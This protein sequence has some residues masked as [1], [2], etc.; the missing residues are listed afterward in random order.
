[1]CTVATGAEP[2]SRKPGSTSSDAGPEHNF[3]ESVALFGNRAL[4]GAAGVQDAG[5]FTGAAYV[6][7]RDDAGAWMQVAKLTANDMH[8]Q[9]YFG[10]AVALFGDR[11]L[12]GVFADDDMGFTS[13][14]AYVFERDASGVW[15]QTAKLYADDGDSND[16]FGTAVAL[17]GERA[18]V[19]ASGDEDR[20]MGAGAAYVLER[21]GRG[22]WVQVQKLLASDGAAI[23]VFGAAVS[24]SGKRALVGA[25]RDDDMGEE[26][27]A[28]YVFE[29][30]SSGTWTE[31]AKLTASDGTA[32][33][34]LGAVS[35]SGGRALLGASKAV[36]MGVTTGAAYVFES[37]PDRG[38]L[39]V[40]ALHASDG[41]ANDYFGISVSVLGD[42]ALVGAHYED[43]GLYGDQ[44]AAYVY[45]LGVAETYCQST[46]NSTGAPAVLAVTGSD[47]VSANELALFALPV[48]PGVGYFCFGG[49]RVHRPFG[50]GVLCAGGPHLRLGPLGTESYTLEQQLDLSTPPLAGSVFGGSRWNL[51]AVF[52]DGPA[53]GFNTSSALTVLFRP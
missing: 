24:L 5:L 21:N 20:G 50:N 10:R 15:N 42:R 1:M 46:L 19:G 18:L 32:G 35:I 34:L 11:A 27:G 2:G 43:H 29:Q 13:G 28:A 51:Q 53:G 8:A 26:S 14:S 6:F 3:G 40:A 38:W 45:P 31:V 49:T 23:D 37:H 17:F 33:A 36:T 7:E 41:A 47:S 4:I 22:A 25:F 12:I 30:D 44:G 9:D 39:E 52:R 48:P 16:G